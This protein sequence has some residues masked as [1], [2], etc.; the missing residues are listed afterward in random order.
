LIYLIKD[1]IKVLS[2]VDHPNI[3]KY[4]ESYENENYIYLVMEYFEGI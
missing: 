1:E 2:T 3:I 4:Y